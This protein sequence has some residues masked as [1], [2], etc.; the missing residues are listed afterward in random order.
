MERDTTPKERMGGEG[1]SHRVPSK[2]EVGPV[3]TEDSPVQ[4]E[5]E[6]GLTSTRG[7][8]KGFLGPWKSPAGSDDERGLEHA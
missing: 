5:D 3:R 6:V 4:Q 1:E 7:S 8:E 2:A